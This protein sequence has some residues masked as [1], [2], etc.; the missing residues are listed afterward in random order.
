MVLSQAAAALDGRVA[1]VT[2]GGSGIGRA[3]AAAFAEFGAKVAVW[4]KVEAAATSAAQ[5]FGALACIT[6]VRD[7]DQVAIC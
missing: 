2:G 4:D 6:D 3:V 7:V 1:V 5:D